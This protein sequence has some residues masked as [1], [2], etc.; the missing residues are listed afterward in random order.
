MN[1]EE[2]CPLCGFGPAR[3]HAEANGR[4]YLHCRNCDLVWL[5]PSLRLD[6]SAELAHYGTHQN[7]PSDSGYRRFLSRLADPLIERLSPGNRGL[8]Y[9]SGPGPTLS[10]MLAERG[11][12]TAIYDPFFAPDV[13]VLGQEYDF[14]TCSETAEHFH[15]PGREFPGFQRMLRPG[16]WLAVM[17]G[18]RPPLAAFPGWHY[19]RD[20]THVC[21]YSRQTLAWI[22][23]RQGWRLE[24]PADNIALFR[25]P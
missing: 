19:L 6:R 8:D 22:A 17:T 1:T 14:I 20:P 24:T 3:V 18:F 21:L 12:P 13:A 2:R 25:K 4:A 15:A 11:F 23:G 9:G 16:G 5:L 7:D 10:V